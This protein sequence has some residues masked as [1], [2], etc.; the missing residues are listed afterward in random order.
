LCKLGL[1]WATLRR[2]G[3]G[4]RLTLQTRETYD[5]HDDIQLWDDFLCST[6]ISHWALDHVGVAFRIAPEL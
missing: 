4:K 1:F 3:D 2:A 5:D 6:T